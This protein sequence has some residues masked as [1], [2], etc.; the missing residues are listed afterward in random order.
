MSETLNWIDASKDVPDENQTVLMF[1][2]GADEPV[3]LGYLDEGTWKLAD[4]MDTDTV[5]SHWCELPEGPK[6]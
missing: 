5:V 6:A 3:W 1:M 2:P 4:G